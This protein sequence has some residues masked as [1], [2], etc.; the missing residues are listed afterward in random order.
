MNK[1]NVKSKTLLILLTISILGLIGFGYLS[2]STYKKDKL[3]FVYDQILSQTQALAQTV[4]LRMEKYELLLG[5]IITQIE[6]GKTELK[7][8]T[9][10][11]LEGQSSLLAMGILLEQD[12]SVTKNILLPNEN[13]KVNWEHMQSL[14]EGLH[15]YKLKSSQFFYKRNLSTQK[16]FAFVFF[17]D[18]ELSQI[19]QSNAQRA[20]AFVNNGRMISLSLWENFPKLINGIKAKLPNLKQVPFGLIDVNLFNKHYLVAYA[21]TKDGGII[22]N[23]ND[24]KALMLVQEV[25]VIQL[26]SF[27]GLMGFIS[28]LVGTI[29]SNWLTRWLDQLAIAA[30]EIEKENFD[31]NLSIKT[32]DEFEVLGNAF[33]SMSARIKNLLEE[34]RLYN[35]QLEQMVA[36]RTRELQHLTNIQKS[37]LNALGQGF[38]M[39]DKGQNVTPVYSKVA[40]EMFEGKPDVVGAF[41]VLNIQEDQRP[42]MSEFLNHVFTETVDFETFGQLAPSERTNAKNQRIF[43]QYAPIRSEQTN[44]LEY[45]M[46]IGT[47]RT[48]EI[49]SKEKFEREWQFSQMI[50]AMVKNR[51]SLCRVINDSYRMLDE[52]KDM[53]KAQGQNAYLDIQRRV[54]TIKGSFAFYYNKEVTG[55]C[56]ELETSLE[57]H[58]KSK[59]SAQN[60]E[61]D[62]QGI[63][64]AIKSF[65]DNY[66]E[67]IGYKQNISG[68]YVPEKNLKAFED[69]LLKEGRSLVM[70]FHDLF[71]QTNIKTQF[72][73]Y[74]RFVKELG[75]KL[76]KDVQFVL[77]GGENSF[78]EGRWSEVLPELVHVVRNAIDHGIET[79]EE[80]KAKGKPATG[81]IRFM[82]EGALEQNAP[83]I[84][85]TLMDDGKGID[86]DALAKKYPDVTD[87]DSAIKKL[88]LGGASSRDT[89]SEFSGRGVGVSA[90]IQKVLELGGR[91][92]M[93]SAKGQGMAIKLW[94][95]IRDQS[96]KLQIAA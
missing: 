39:I 18:I 76:G 65:V 77:D 42:V 6:E 75:V 1:L 68:R 61:N 86:V 3:A 66:D 69:K 11:Y 92:E 93:T 14:P 4:N 5:A 83:W 23:L 53:L 49:A 27:L 2:F 95:P 90:V 57:S 31:I 71:Y 19:L 89:V 41:E 51:E 82:F 21:A 70:T 54:H 12:A 81:E 74:P 79:P 10:G 80:R 59:T 9:K 91:W 64:N 85:M 30:K 43:F 88:A 46:V 60:V 32:G 7:G 33:G 28:L 56:H 48:E 78:P 15:A 36:D 29:A 8:A 24:A 38:V 84:C 35:T 62:L 17:K 67:I 45:V 13:I 20:S 94:L 63:I 55:L 47:D 52:A 25:F 26:A 22:L 58:I 40:E 50:L 96:Q 16:G 87:L 44:E 37:M 73:S 34:L 72:Q